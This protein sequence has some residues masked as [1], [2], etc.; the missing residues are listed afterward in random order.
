M[1]ADVGF[2]T[3]F[4][5]KDPLPNLRSS[6]VRRLEPQGPPR[7]AFRPSFFFPSGHPVVGWKSPE[8]KFRH[9]SVNAQGS[10]EPAGT[11]SGWAKGRTSVLRQQGHGMP[12][13]P[14]PTDRHLQD[15]EDERQRAEL[16]FKRTGGARTARDR[17]AATGSW[18]G[19]SG[20]GSSWSCGAR[21]ES[22]EGLLQSRPRRSKSAG[23][24][25]RSACSRV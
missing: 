18:S 5:P 9:G 23:P 4:W 16:V 20:A 17:L 25:L 6:P 3:L 11:A 15:R 1:C 13:R 7:C 24:Q 12:S 19:R 22:S 10:T 14:S 2:H 21:T 8:T